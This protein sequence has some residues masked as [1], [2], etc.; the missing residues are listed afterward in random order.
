MRGFITISIF[1]LV[2][3]FSLA[4]VMTVDDITAE[5][6]RSIK[7]IK[8]IKYSVRNTTTFSS[9]NTRAVD[10]MA[11]I[12]VNSN[13]TIL[14]FS[15][16]GIRNDNRSYIYKDGYG[17]NIYD[18]DGKFRREKGGKYILG[19]PGGQMIYSDYFHL[20]SIYSSLEVEETDSSLILFYEFEDDLEKGYSDMTKVLELNKKTY[21]PITVTTT[22]QPNTGG[23]QTINYTFTDYKV[24]DS[25]DK[26][27]ETYLSNLSNFELLKEEE[28]TTSALLN[29]RLPDLRMKLLDD[30][31]I[32]KIDT[33]GK[34]IL[35]DFWEYWCGWCIKSFPDIERIKS[36]FQEDL[37]VIG[38]VSDNEEHA[39]KLAFDKGLTFKNYVGNKDIHKIFNVNSFP[40]YFLVDKM[41]IVRR[42]YHGYS[43]EIEM[44]IK[45]LI[46]N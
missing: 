31:S 17:F 23:I 6:N 8:K 1:L 24:N 37:I 7:E 41:G 34:L 27:I 2:T 13:D 33:E 40:R 44:D 3:R 22:L 28:P 14:G 42:E 11:V 9:G 20:D 16:Y 19:S 21:L 26:N 4:Q 38:I 29:K 36:S 10:G 35:I 5:F 45:A 39:R 43:T 30:E 25:V 46:S 12:E 32:E 18:E 15:F